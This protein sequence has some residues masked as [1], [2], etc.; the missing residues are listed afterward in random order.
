M[1]MHD[2]RIDYLFKDGRII[3]KEESDKAKLALFSKTLKEGQILE[4]YMSVQKPS[5]ASLG[6]IAKVHAMIKELSL[7]TGESFPE[8]KNVVK[9]KAGLY[10]VVDSRSGEIELKSFAICSKEELSKAI[11]ACIEIGDVVGMDLH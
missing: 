4:V 11:Q 10:S 9:H 7:F 1:P 6:Q 5:D 3:P 2:L 8:L